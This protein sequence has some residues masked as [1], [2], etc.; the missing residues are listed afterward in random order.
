M[1]RILWALPVEQVTQFTVGGR[2]IHPGEFTASH[3]NRIWLNVTLILWCQD[4]GA[5][6]SVTWGVKVEVT[7]R[8]AG[9]GGVIGE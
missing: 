6:Q 4:K 9:A 7:L 2:G 3:G 5:S 1:A 8:A